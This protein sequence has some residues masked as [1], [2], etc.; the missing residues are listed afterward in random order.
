MSLLT[1]KIQIKEK[2]VILAKLFKWETYQ[3]CYKKYI[4]EIPRRGKKILVKQSYNN[5]GWLII[6][7]QKQ[8]IKLNT[9]D[10]LEFMI[11]IKRII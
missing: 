11:E 8:K 2:P 4:I 7:N 1:S 9:K 5:N 3:Y 10:T 6:F